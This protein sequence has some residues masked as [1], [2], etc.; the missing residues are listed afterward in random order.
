MARL[1]I[2]ELYGK[3]ND[4]RESRVIEIRRKPSSIQSTAGHVKPGGNMG[5]P[6][7]KPKYYPVTDRVIV[8]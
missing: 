4:R 6:P 5:G 2:D 1:R 8:L 7:S 3:T